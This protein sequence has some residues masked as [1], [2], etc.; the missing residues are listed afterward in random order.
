MVQIW[1]LR[2]H[3]LSSKITNKTESLSGKPYTLCHRAKLSAMKFSLLLILG[4][5]GF[6]QGAAGQ[7]VQEDLVP[8]GTK[9]KKFCLD[10]EGNKY[11]KNEKLTGMCEEYTCSFKKKKYSWKVKVSAHTDILA[12]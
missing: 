8:M 4:V 10:N 12:K 11:K 7:S 5:L 2:R 9:W 3:H 6:F 1:P